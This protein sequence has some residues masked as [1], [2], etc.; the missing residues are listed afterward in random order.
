[1]EQDKRRPSDPAPSSPPPP[2]VPAAS[3]A[4]PAAEAATA[5]RP[6]G[7]LRTILYALLLLLVLGAGAG[8][9]WFVFL[10]GIVY[11]DDAR[12][13]GDLVEVAPRVGGVITKLLVREG[14]PVDSGQVLFELDDK[15]FAAA[16]QSARA[17]V[18][19]AQAR[20]D[21]AKAANEKALHGPRSAEIRIALEAKK[22]A[23][24]QARL[25]TVEWERAKMMFE[26]D[27]L[28]DAERVKLQ[29]AW[30]RATGAAAEAA[31][32]LQLLYQGTRGEDLA[33]ARANVE[34]AEAD[35]AAA[36]AACVQAELNLDYARV[37]APFAGV[38]VRKWRD[39]GATIAVG[40]P[41]FTLLDPSTLHVSANIEEKELAEVRVGD[42]VEI[43]VDAY[44]EAKLHG[45]VQTILRATNSQFSLIPSSGVSGTF[46]KVAQRMPLR[47]ALE[48][49]AGDLQL[50]PGLSVEIRVLVGSGRR[51]PA[52][53]SSRD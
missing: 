46:I 18:A 35:L 10:R 51:S 36:Q 15:V 11:S 28:T 1:M 37:T 41:V 6:A 8:S 21:G 43:D 31:D 33:A 39:A 25:A 9:Y 44:P 20:L 49:P 13:D 27:L 3:D 45:R 40:T 32:R 29:T 19:G 48:Q 23:D 50:A 34:R 47:I 42:R 7:R 16:L 24:A 5:G 52:V 4:A 53:V 30:E 22:S 12:I 2:T 26:K 17:A 38:V 14:D